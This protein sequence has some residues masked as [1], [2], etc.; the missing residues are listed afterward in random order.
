M[1]DSAGHAVP[2]PRP[3]RTAVTAVAT[4]T[5][6]AVALRTAVELVTVRVAALRADEDRPRA[7]RAE[8][9]ADPAREHP[10]GPQAHLVRLGPSAA[11]AGGL[12][13]L[14]APV[15]VHRHHGRRRHAHRARSAR[16]GAARLVVVAQ[17]ISAVARAGVHQGFGAEPERRLQPPHHVFRALSQRHPCRELGLARLE[18]LRR[19]G[20]RHA[21]D[22]E[23]ETQLVS[24][25]GGQRSSRWARSDVARGPVEFRAR[26]MT[27]HLAAR[28]PLATSVNNSN[29]RMSVTARLR[30]RASRH[31]RPSNRSIPEIEDRADPAHGVFGAH[32]DVARR[33]DR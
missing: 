19:T 26:R 27:R 32:S 21:R 2:A 4:A 10:R 23:G 1:P 17:K 24:F 8:R 14:P 7:G 18:D 29:E 22:S 25:L 11:H 3:E 20:L 15:P 5:H 13:L 33:C 12:T 30:A 31:R 9:H 16:R 6:P 28:T